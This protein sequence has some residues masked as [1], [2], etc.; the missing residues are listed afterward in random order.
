MSANLHDLTKEQ[1]IG[2][3]RKLEGSLRTEQT[4]RVRAVQRARDAT[5]SLRVHVLME[6][7]S[8][9]KPVGVYLTEALAR[10]RQSR[11]RRNYLVVF[12]LN[13]AS[14]QVPEVIAIG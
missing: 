10:A 5:T 3:V 7:A 4:N 12:E 13:A 6:E 14:T 2:L 9:D 11:T 1:L 8:P